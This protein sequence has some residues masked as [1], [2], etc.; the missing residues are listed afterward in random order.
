MPP[1]VLDPH[2][3]KMQ[4]ALKKCMFIP[5]VRDLHARPGLLLKKAGRVEERPAPSRS[6]GSFTGDPLFVGLMLAL[7]PPLG[8]V[9]LW[10]SPRY[11]DEA[12]RAISMMMGLTMVLGTLVAC[13]A[14]L[15]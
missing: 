14:I 3:L 11:S 13:T 9:L 15:F 7:L 2:R 12:R 10:T 5:P 1:P 4:E 8:F 6:K